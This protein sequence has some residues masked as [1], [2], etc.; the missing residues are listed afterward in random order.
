MTRFAILLDG[1]LKAS[2]RLKTQV[3]GCQIIAAD[4]GIRHAETLGL[5]P[6]IWLGDFDSAP[7]EALKKYHSIPRL[8]FPRD[9]DLTD[10]EIAVAEALKRGATSLILIGAFGGKRADHAL[11]HK[12]MALRLA[13][14]GLSVTLSDGNQEGH[15]V[16]PGTKRYDFPTG[17]L[18]SLIGFDPLSGLT[19]RGAKWPLENT[20]TP[21][22]SSLTLSNVVSNRLEIELAAGKALLIA[23]I[24]T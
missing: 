19:I 10:G 21:T 1:D 18:F 12:L 3:E 15:P 16:L 23:Q 20:K 22:G 2:T 4:G 17:T 5:T 13:G 24:E 11:L 6:D 8:T 14:D 7:G 9:K